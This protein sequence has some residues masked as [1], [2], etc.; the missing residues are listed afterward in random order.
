[1][2]E[3]CVRPF[4]SLKGAASPSRNPLHLYISICFYGLFHRTERKQDGEK[5]GVWLCVRIYWQS[6]FQNPLKCKNTMEY[7]V[8][9]RLC[10]CQTYLANSMKSSMMKMCFDLWSVSTLQVQLD[11]EELKRL[12]S[13]AKERL[14]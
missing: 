12:I 1:M 13:E 7:F 10:S 8:F 9:F 3:L 6:F 4:F 5:G 14:Q 2:L 11:R